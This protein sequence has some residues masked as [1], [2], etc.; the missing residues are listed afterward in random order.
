MFSSKDYAGMTL[1]ELVA[2]N[3]K[4]KS[5]AIATAFVIGMV[6]GLA[7]WVATHKGGFIFTIG[8]L[9]MGFFIGN[10]HSQNKKILQAEIS[11]RETNS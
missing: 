2:E 10:K 8:L 6:V 3:K 7:V 11:R 1:E 4:M 5:G 9:G